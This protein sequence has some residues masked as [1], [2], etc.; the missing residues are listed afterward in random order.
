VNAHFDQML[1][2]R[3]IQ[4]ERP[5]K[6]HKPL[7]APNGSMIRSSKLVGTRNGE[8]L[9]LRYAS[10]ALQGRRTVAGG[11]G[12]GDIAVTNEYS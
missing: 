4:P 12:N 2:G 11:N 5:A 10:A 3:A 7:E 6:V 8:R 9:A 1:V